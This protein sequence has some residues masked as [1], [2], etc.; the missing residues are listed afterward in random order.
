M[1]I[2]WN[3]Y[4]VGEIIRSNSNTFI[5]RAKKL[6][7]DLE[8]TPEKL[9]SDRLLTLTGYYNKRGLVVGYTIEYK[10]KPKIILEGFY[11]LLDYVKKG[12]KPKD[13]VYP[14]LSSK[15]T[16]ISLVK[17]GKILNNRMYIFIY[18]RK[19]DGGS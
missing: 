1:E 8:P 13:M 7:S 3:N 14:K 15:D 17:F 12:E 5:L 19:N 16:A 2:E 6:V 11:L 10:E 9:F 18:R 4:P